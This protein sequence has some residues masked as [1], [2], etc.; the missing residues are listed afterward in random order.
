MRAFAASRRTAAGSSASEQ[1]WQRAAACRTES[2]RLTAAT[3]A[4]FAL[5]PTKYWRWFAS[6][7]EASCRLADEHTEID[8][9]GTTKAEPAGTTPHFDLGAVVEAKIPRRN[10]YAWEARAE[11]TPHSALE[12]AALE[13]LPARAGD[14]NGDLCEERLVGVECADRW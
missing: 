12:E 7:D 9:L 14:A 10:P 3:G 2:E 4:T 8:V 13:H 5:V 6:P 1:G 11:Q